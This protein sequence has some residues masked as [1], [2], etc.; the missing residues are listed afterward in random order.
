[1]R[2]VT[3]GASRA[4]VVTAKY[5]IK[6]PYFWRW[7]RVTLCL[8]ANLSE[9]HHWANREMNGWTELC[10]V[11]YCAPLGLFLVMPA[12]QMMT[13]EQYEAWDSFDNPLK[14]DPYPMPPYES[15]ADDWGYVDG[16]PVIVDYSTDVY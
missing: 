16:K 14:P 11:L 1:M 5:A 8:R 15:K 7:N 3:T 6:I 4:V 2:L 9:A 13:F 12:A 10:P